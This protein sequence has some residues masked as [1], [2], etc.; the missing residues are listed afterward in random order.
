MSEWGG[1]DNLNNEETETAA[2]STPAEEMPAT[3]ASAEGISEEEVSAAEAVVENVP[4]DES[5][6][7]DAVNS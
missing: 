1:F 4:A 2:E 5:A 6:S 3:G 7:R